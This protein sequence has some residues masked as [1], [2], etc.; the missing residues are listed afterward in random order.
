MITLLTYVYVNIN[1]SLL[2][3][4]N[5]REFTCADKTYK[6]KTP[7]EPDIEKSTVIVDYPPHIANKGMPTMTS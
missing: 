6:A 2:K 4:H 5:A 1:K 3:T 7:C